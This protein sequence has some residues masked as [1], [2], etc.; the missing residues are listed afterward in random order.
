MPTISSIAA[1]PYPNMRWQNASTA[2]S[3]LVSM[4]MCAQPARF[5]PPRH[6]C[7]W[8]LS[9]MRSIGVDYFCQQW[10]CGCHFRTAPHDWCD[11]SKVRPRLECPLWL[12]GWSRSRGWR[13]PTAG[14]NPIKMISL[15]LFGNEMKNKMKKSAN[16]NT[17][18]AGICFLF[19]LFCHFH[20]SLIESVELWQV[21]AENELHVNLFLWGKVFFLCLQ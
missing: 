10:Q 20:L 12:R 21:H 16:K 19:W 13:R 7:L 6:R 1:P 2:N 3:R 5:L 8:L 18:H 17:I 9:T 11:L 14:G 15:E 4:R